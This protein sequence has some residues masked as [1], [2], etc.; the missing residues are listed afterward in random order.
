[1]CEQTHLR[2]SETNWALIKEKH[3]HVP[4]ISEFRMRDKDFLDL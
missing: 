2:D 4:S 3:I 1:M